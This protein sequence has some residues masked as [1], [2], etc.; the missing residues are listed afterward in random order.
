MSVTGPISALQVEQGTVRACQTPQRDSRAAIVALGLSVCLGDLEE[1]H[2][3]LL[4]QISSS[5]K[6]DLSPTEGV[7]I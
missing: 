7:T 3:L 4:A 5:A 1:I 6:R 2:E